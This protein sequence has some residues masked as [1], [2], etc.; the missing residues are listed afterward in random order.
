MVTHGFTDD[1][2]PILLQ[3]S[4]GY[5]AAYYRNIKTLIMK[6]LQIE[7]NL[8]VFLDL[9]SGLGKALEIA[10]GTNIFESVVGVELDEN[11]H[12][13]STR[14]FAQPSECVKLLNIDAGNY[15]MENSSTLVYLFNPFDNIILKKFLLKNI[16]NFA[17]NKSLIAYLN[18]KYND[19]LIELGFEAVYFNEKK[20]MSI[21][22][23]RYGR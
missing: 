8:K 20:K 16:E 17:K 10:N 21:W 9:G 18:H 14:N 22:K 11:L 2:N 1:I 7:K 15:K 13:A 23:I 3:H 19:V 4:N 6:S 5:Q 12:K